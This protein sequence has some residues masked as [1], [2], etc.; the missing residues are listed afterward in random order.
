M[1]SFRFLDNNLNKK[2]I[3]LIEGS[4]VEH[5]VDPQGTIHYSN[6]LIVDN[7]LIPQVRNTIFPTW[8]VLSCPQSSEQQYRQYM[9]QHGIKFMGE[10]ID[11]K[12]HFLLSRNHD[13]HSWNLK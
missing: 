13:P 5:T 9:T 11:G 6:D 2:L 3:A 8:Q 10:I 7:D 1:Y 12:L 4:D